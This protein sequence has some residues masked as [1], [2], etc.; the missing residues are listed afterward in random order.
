MKQSPMPSKPFRQISVT[1]DSST[2]K[3]KKEADVL[4][5]THTPIASL[6]PVR[7]APSVTSEPAAAL[8]GYRSAR[9]RWL[10]TAFKF[11]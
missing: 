5:R 9:R 11:G 6:R 3:A 2:A 7:A 10:A 8:L 4:Q 1:K